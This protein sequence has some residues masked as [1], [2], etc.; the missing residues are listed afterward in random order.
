MTLRAGASLS[1]AERVA[2]LWEQ[3]RLRRALGRREEALESA[4]QVVEREPEHVAALALLAEV[5]ATS[6]RLEEAAEALVRLST[7]KETPVSQRRVARQGAIDIFEHR[8]KLPQRAIELL[9]RM[10][11]EGEANDGTIE[12]G[13][14]LAMTAGLWE[15]ALRFARVAAERADGPADRCRQLL[16]VCD[17]VV[18]GQALKAVVHIRRLGRLELERQRLERAGGRVGVGHFEDGGHAAAGGG[19]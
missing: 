1:D 16:Q 10:V 8:L 3:A 13:V 12:R 2:L 4:V 18:T 9:E 14:S 6:G 5:H 15:E 17:G 7:A 11:V 19:G